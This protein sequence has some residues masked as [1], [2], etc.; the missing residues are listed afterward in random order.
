MQYLLTAVFGALIAAAFVFEAVEAAKT[1][2]WV[3]YPL[4]F[5]TGFASFLLARV[6]YRA[7]AEGLTARATREQLD[8]EAEAF[9]SD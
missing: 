6:A 8:A 4:V 3:A 2:G 5:G 9:R 1:L 7:V